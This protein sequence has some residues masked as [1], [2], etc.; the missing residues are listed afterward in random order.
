MCIFLNFLFSQ[1]MFDLS[2]SEN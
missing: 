1:N 2:M